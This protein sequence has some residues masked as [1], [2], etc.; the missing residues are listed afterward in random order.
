MAARPPPGFHLAHWGVV[1]ASVRELPAI[2]LL[3][4]THSLLSTRAE[5]DTA[6]RNTP[7]TDAF[8][9]V[10]TLSP[11]S[12][13]LCVSSLTYSP[14]DTNSCVSYHTVCSMLKSSPALSEL[15]QLCHLL[16]ACHTH[17]H[18]DKYNNDCSCFLPML[19]LCSC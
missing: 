6:R 5:P 13:T 4:Q 14:S 18:T 15:T 19:S 7:C 9:P 10:W 11:P 3:I 16:P 17:A 8:D 2:H 12:V 1:P